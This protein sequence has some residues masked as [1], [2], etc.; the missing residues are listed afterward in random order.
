MS[1]PSPSPENL[2]D[3]GIEPGSPTLQAGALPSEPP[4]NPLTIS[5]IYLFLKMFKCHLSLHSLLRLFSPNCNNLITA[6]EGKARPSTR[7]IFNYPFQASF[8]H[9][10]I[11]SSQKNLS[12]FI[13][14]VVEYLVYLGYNKISQ[15]KHKVKEP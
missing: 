5:Y 9:L 1:H 13:R 14:Y 15:P 7:N 6:L 3:P 10:F 4:E 2:P 8:P 11:H 12:Y